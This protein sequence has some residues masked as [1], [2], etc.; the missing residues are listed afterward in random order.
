MSTPNKNHVSI[1]EICPHLLEDLKD[2]SEK[3]VGLMNDVKDLIAYRMEPSTMQENVRTIQTIINRSIEQVR[4][5]CDYL[6]AEN[7]TNQEAYLFSEE[8]MKG[9]HKPENISPNT[10]PRNHARPGS[11]VARVGRDE[12]MKMLKLVCAR[13]RKNRIVTTGAA[14]KCFGFTGSEHHFLEVWSTLREF[15]TNSPLKTYGILRYDK[16]NKGYKWD[17]L[18]DFA[19]EYYGN[20]HES[21]CRHI[22]VGKGAYVKRLKGEPFLKI[23]V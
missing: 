23:E 22:F 11:L 4:R 19:R 10:A 20:Y 21:M 1:S 16:M 14:C 6:L 8:E 13:D 3:V 9:L 7:R 17:E 5:I 2:G 18:M 12:C 15:G